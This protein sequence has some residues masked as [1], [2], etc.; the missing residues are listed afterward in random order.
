MVRK[1]RILTVSLGALLAT[2]LVVGCGGS[3]PD[4]LPKT[5]F[6]KQGN[7]ICVNAAKKR[8]TAVTELAEKN[9]GGGP[10][11]LVNDAALPPTKEMVEELDDLG[12]PEGDEKQVEAIV[13]GLEE[14]IEK[15]E[16]NPK[17]ALGSSAFE[18]PNE[19]ALAYGLSECAI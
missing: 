8:E 1:R 5:A 11:E 4:P 10:E 15:V 12:V 14:G 17:E 9:G 16:A 7:Q 2:A 13:T 19:A 18:K 3:E 6:L